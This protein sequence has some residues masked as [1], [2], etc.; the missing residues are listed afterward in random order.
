MRGREGKRNKGRSQLRQNG[1]RPTL[2]DLPIAAMHAQM[3]KALGM[4]A[5]QLCRDS[6]DAAPL[7]IPHHQV[8]SPPCM[9]REGGRPIPPGSKRPS[10]SRGRHRF[11]LAVKATRTEVLNLHEQFC[12]GSCGFNCHS[13]TVRCTL[14]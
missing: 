2:L 7:P 12:S 8:G 5:S 14:S 3:T 9:L 6:L 4:L 1:K 10:H 13:P 11:N